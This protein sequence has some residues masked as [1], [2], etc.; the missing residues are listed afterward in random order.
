MVSTHDLVTLVD[1]KTLADAC[2]NLEYFSVAEAKVI[3]DRGIQYLATGCPKLHS[4]ELNVLQTIT[5]EGLRWVAKCTNLKLLNL[6]WVVNVTSAG[7]Q[8]L[9][10]LKELK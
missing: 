5:D 4:L 2:P 7:I 8:E 10:N 1:V 9:A 3:G 6:H